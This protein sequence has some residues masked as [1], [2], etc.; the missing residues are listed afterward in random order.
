MGMGGGVRED[1][2]SNE[3]FCD[4]GGTWREITVTVTSVS[5]IEQIMKM[6][7]W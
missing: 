1:L 2:L 3:P 7:Y 4:A 6:A 5:V